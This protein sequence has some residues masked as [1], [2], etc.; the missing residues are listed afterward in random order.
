MW[1]ESDRTASNRGCEPGTS[2]SVTDGVGGNS[3][4]PIV[5]L[6]QRDMLTARLASVSCLVVTTTAT[7][8]K[9]GATS[10]PT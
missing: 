8:D 7:V 3:F 9:R 10:E 6:I 1:L 2:G 5:P 4:G